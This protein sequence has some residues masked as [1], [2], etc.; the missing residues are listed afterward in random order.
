MRILLTELHRVRTEGGDVA[1][2]IG[3][4]VFAPERVARLMR[5][6]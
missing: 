1:L 2:R 5:G 3:H 4:H 6:I